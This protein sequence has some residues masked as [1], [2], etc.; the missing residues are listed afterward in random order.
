[1]SKPSR[2]ALTVTSTLVAIGLL[3]SAVAMAS[4]RSNA[5]RPDAG[6]DP[7]TATIV[8]KATV[9]DVLEGRRLALQPEEDGAGRIEVQLADDVR[10]RAQN[11]KEF[12]GRKKLVFDDFVVGQK[13]RITVLPAQERILSF[14]VLKG[15]DWLNT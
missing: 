3:W 5:A 7:A 15:G 10:I 11:K 4:T 2:P 9:V 14:V 1:M 8:V 12:N 13:L 6:R